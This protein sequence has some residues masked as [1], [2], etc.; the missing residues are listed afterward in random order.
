MLTTETVKNIVLSLFAL[1][2]SSFF[3]VFIPLW[4][5]NSDFK[6][7]SIQ[8]GVLRF[9]GLIPMAVGTGMFIWCYGILVFSGR[10]TPWPL[11]PP[12]K[13]VTSGF[14]R[15][16]RNPIMFGYLLIL[17]GEGLFFESS[18]LI[19]YLIINFVLL[20]IRTIFIEEPMLK[21]RFGKPYENYYKTT[22]RWIPSFKAFKKATLIDILVDGWASGFRRQVAGLNDGV[23]SDDLT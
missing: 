8:L 14:Y 19:L 3:I 1:A 2:Y 10:G 5:I 18:S 4:I 17:F 20:H 6:L 15:F 11:N 22:P 16:M 13:L 21:D 9:I 23:C 12:K 7:I